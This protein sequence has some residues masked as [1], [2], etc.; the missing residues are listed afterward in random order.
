M[1]RKRR[2]SIGFGYIGFGNK[3]EAFNRKPKE[4]F[5]ELKDSYNAEVHEDHELN[6]NEN[7][8]S[9][10]DRDRIKNRI[11][12]AKKRKAIKVIIISILVFVMLFFVLKYLANSI[13]Y[14]N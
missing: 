10:E 2:H 6:F 1:R 9:D 14:Q 3:H 7:K 13:L 11:Q 8:L 12:K 5:T 4:A